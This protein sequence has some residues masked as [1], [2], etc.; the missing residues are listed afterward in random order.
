MP[1]D[2]GRFQDKV[3]VITGSGSGIGEALAHAFAAEGPR[4]VVLADLRG[5]VAVANELGD[6]AMAFTCDVTDAAQVRNMIQTVRKRWGRIDIYCSNAG[7]MIPPT[8]TTT[9]TNQDHVAKYSDDQWSRVFSVNV[10]SHVIAARELISDE[11]P[12]HGGV[13]VITASAAGVLAIPEDASYGVSKAAAVSFAE[14]LAIIHHPS[15][16]VLCLCPMAVDTPFIAESI[17]DAPLNSA[18]LDGIV[19]A[20][21]VA[22]CTLDAIDDR[23]A[24]WIFPHEKVPKY[25]QSKANQHARWL[26]GMQ[27]MRQRL[28]AQGQELTALSKL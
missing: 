8:T 28:L 16:R 9:T 23:Q 3:V 6:I 11:D 10:Q 21:R 17:G 25:I 26:M 24:F 13:F 14:H 4:V 12:W 22:E 2:R 27:R 5:H 1:T 18:V 20:E 19:S 15:L 7:I